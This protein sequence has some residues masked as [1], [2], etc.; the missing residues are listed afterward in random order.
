MDGHSGALEAE[1]VV[2]L[3]RWLLRTPNRHSA[4]VVAL[5]D[6]KSVLCAASKGRSSA[7]SIKRAVRRMGALALAGDLH[8]KFVY[9][10]SEDNPADGPSRGVLRR[11]PSPVVKPVRKTVSKQ[12]R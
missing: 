4:R 9:V 6:A 3:L 7:P 12:S 10:P 5:V 2:L 1:A 11:R 8:M